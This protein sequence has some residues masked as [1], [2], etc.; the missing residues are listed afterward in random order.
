MPNGD[1]DDLICAAY[2]ITQLQSGGE[3]NKLDLSVWTFEGNDFTGGV[4]G[5]QTRNQDW[6]GERVGDK[7]AT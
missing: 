5:S 1:K 7:V 4:D 3:K 2:A 6:C